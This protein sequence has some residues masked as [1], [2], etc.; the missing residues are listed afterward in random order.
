MNQIAMATPF[1]I[2]GLPSKKVLEQA[3]M[4]H[5]PE[6]SLGVVKIH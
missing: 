4:V 5:E 2:A 6:A 1:N 3:W